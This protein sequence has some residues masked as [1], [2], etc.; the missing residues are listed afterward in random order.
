MEDEH[1]EQIFKGD[2]GMKDKIIDEIQLDFS[3]VMLM[4][5][6]SNLTS[7]KDVD[8]KRKYTFRW[9]DSVIYATGITQANMG[10]I[11]TFPVTRKMLDTGMTACLHKHHDID[12]LV[13][14]YRELDP[15]TEWNRCFLSIGING[16][17]LEKLEILK[18]RVFGSDDDPSICIDV[19][20]GYIGKVFEL[21]REVRKKYPK[22]IIMAGNVV[23]SD[24]AGK[25]LLCGADIVKIGI[26]GG[27]QCMTRIQTG[28]GRPQLSTILDCAETVH[29]LGGR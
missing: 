10:T 20:N 6:E 29:R 17:G 4:P 14:F 22:S 9:T 28:V 16:N 11:G 5:K 21:V 23:T 1:H 18:E 12:K 27:S 2:W 13:E 25:L 8:V 3:D 24:V 26:G 19:P 7:R 15:D